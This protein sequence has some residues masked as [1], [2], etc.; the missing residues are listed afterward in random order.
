MNEILTDF[1]QYLRGEKDASSA[2]VRA[3]LNDL[4]KFFRWYLET[5]GET[6]KFDAIGALDIAEFKRYMQ[7]R[8]QKPATINRALACLST[9]FTWAVER[10]HA[11]QNPAGGV[12]PVPEVKPAPKALGRREQL[13]LMRA[14]QKGGRVRDIA[15]VTLLLHA[16]LRVS[17]VCALTLDDI[18]LGERSGKVIIR[19][20]KGGKRREVPLN[21]TARKAIKDW[22]GVR[23]EAPGPLF[24]S[25]KG[26]FLSAR[27]VEYL[28]A[29]YAYN[30]HLEKVTPHVLRHTFC[31]SL[32]DA[33]ES[34]DRVAVLAGHSNLNTTA[35]YTRPSDDDLQRAVDRLAWE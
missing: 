2:T 33:G 8:G 13:A 11:A 30:A 10:G 15:I 7:N 5:T 9:F 18:V 24:T 20:G 27:A 19:L 4:E 25:Q 21:A 14:V 22:L 16:G 28:L 32:I 29:K 6:P 1:E 17:E 23:G 31:K 12:K 35:R 26:G 3:Y 34:L